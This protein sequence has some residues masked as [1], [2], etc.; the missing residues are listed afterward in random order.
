MEYF[1]DNTGLLA[2]KYNDNYYIYQKDAFGTT[3]GLL[4]SNGNAVDK[5]LIIL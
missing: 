1:Y 3:K 5:W 4:D 2:C